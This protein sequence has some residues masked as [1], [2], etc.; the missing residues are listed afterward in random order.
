MPFTPRNT[1][2][3]GLAK[4]TVTTESGIKVH[5]VK[6]KD[7][8]VGEAVNGSE[9][10]INKDV[11]KDSELYAREMAQGKIYYNEHFVR[12]NGKEYPRKNGKIKYNGKWHHEG[13]HAFPWEK[14]AVKAEK[15]A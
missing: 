11:N 15:K 12:D 2:L 3:P 4:K 10:L 8:I 5:H 1:P 9:V 13:S 14:R 6:L 7:G